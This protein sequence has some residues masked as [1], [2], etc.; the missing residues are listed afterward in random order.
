[1]SRAEGAW[2]PNWLFDVICID[3]NL[4]DRLSQEFNAELREVEWRGQSIGE[5]RQLVVPSAAD[6]WFDHDATSRAATQAHGTPGSVCSGCGTWRWMPLTFEQL[7]APKL[8]Q[9]SIGR[10]IIASHEW[11]GDGWKSFRKILLRTELATVIADASPRD[12]M[13]RT[14]PLA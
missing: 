6:D 4:A 10:D 7:P 12:F 5:A 13:A 11:F 14:V 3:G 8:E 1:M 9:E 2:V